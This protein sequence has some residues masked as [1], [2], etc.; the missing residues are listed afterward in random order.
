MICGNNSIILDLCQTSACFVKGIKRSDFCN[1]EGYK[2]NIRAKKKSG[3]MNRS[4][5]MYREQ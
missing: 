3:S 2:N 1:Y 4:L 5:S